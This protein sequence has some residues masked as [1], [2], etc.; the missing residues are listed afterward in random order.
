VREVGERGVLTS[1]SC[2]AS[3]GDGVRSTTIP[4][5]SKLLGHEARNLLVSRVGWERGEGERLTA[6]SW[7]AFFWGWCAVHN[8]RGFETA[9]A[10]DWTVIVDAC[11]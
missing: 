11:G 7:L 5:A 10:I 4:D 6:N 9:I 8:P 2:L 1:I 3:F